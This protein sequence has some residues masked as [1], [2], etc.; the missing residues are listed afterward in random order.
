SDLPGGGHRYEFARTRPLPSYL[1]ALGVGPFEIVDAGKTKSGVPVRIVTLAGHTA[2]AAWAAKVTA[3]ALDLLEEWFGIPY[4][5]DKADMLVIPTTV[6]F[7]AMENPGLVTYAQ[8]YILIDPTH[9]SWASRYKYVLG[10]THELSHQ[11]FGD[12]VTTAWWDDIWLNEG[13]ANWME[14][15]TTARFEPA[16][17]D[18]LE[19]LEM[20]DSALGADSV[21]TARAVRQPIEKVDDIL[22]AF[23]G[24]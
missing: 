22:D 23:D 18:E 12:Y 1:I 11:W 21:I 19:E 2:D 20:R 4:P 8:D 15:K 9:P 6:G 16:W 17:H 5:Y 13:F 3:R 14:K 10:A 24:I 7:G